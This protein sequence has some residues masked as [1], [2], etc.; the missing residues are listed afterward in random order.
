MT[1]RSLSPPSLLVP[2]L[3]QYQSAHRSSI[4]HSVS[5]HCF[6][7]CFHIHHLASVHLVE[8]YLFLECS[9]FSRSWQGRLAIIARPFD[10]LQ[11]M[12]LCPEE[13]HAAIV[14]I[15]YAHYPF[16]WTF[17]LIFLVSKPTYYLHWSSS[18]WI[19]LV[20]FYKVGFMSLLVLHFCST[21]N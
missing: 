16:I 5:L 20:S 17:N 13:E 4:I 1:I 7:F 19:I 11:M 14:C 2:V 9:F 8:L 18:D 12:K 21:N 3:F 6:S 15:W 10:D